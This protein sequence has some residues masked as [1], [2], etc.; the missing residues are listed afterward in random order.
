MVQK[1]YDSTEPLTCEVKMRKVERIYSPGCNFIDDSVLICILVVQKEDCVFMCFAKLDNCLGSVEYVYYE[2]TSIPQSIRRMKEFLYE[3]DVCNELIVY[4]RFEDDIDSLEEM[5]NFQMV[6]QHFCDLNAREHDFVF[7]ESFQN[8]MY[9]HLYACHNV[10]NDVKKV[11]QVDHL[12]LNVNA[13]IILLLRFAQEHDPNLIK[14]IKYPSSYSALSSEKVCC[15]NSV[16]EKIDFFTENRG[17]FSLLSCQKTRMGNRLFRHMLRNPISNGETLAFRY[18]CIQHFWDTSYEIDKLL[19]SI[20]DFDKIQRKLELSKVSPNDVH[21][22]VVSF[23]SSVVLFETLSSDV[24][25]NWIGD[26]A[27]LRSC[28]LYIE[29]IF[30]LKQCMNNVNGIMDCEFVELMQLKSRRDQLYNTIQEVIK[31]LETLFASHMNSAVQSVVQLHVTAGGEY[32]LQ[33]TLKRAKMI[34]NALNLC[35]DKPNFIQDFVVVQSQKN[36]TLHGSF[37][38]HLHQYANVI[39]E[40]NEVR[41]HK[42]LETVEHVCAK[43]SVFISD[44]SEFVSNVDVFYTFAKMA[45]SRSYVRPMIMDDVGVIRSTA[46]RHPIIEDIVRKDGKEYVTNDVE[47]GPMNSWILHGVN[48]VGKSS[49]L[50]SIVVNVVLAQCGFFVAADTFAFNPFCVIGCRIGNDDDLFCGQS[51]FVKECIEMDS[52]MTKSHANPTLVVTDEMCSSTESESARKVVASFIQVLSERRVTFACATHLF[53]LQK[54]NFIRGLRNVKNFHLDVKVDDKHVVFLRKLRP[55]L[56]SIQEYGTIV[57]KC[58][59]KDRR[60]QSLVQSSWHTEREND[61]QVSVSSYNRRSLRIK[62]E[63]CEYKPQTPLDSRL[64]THHIKFQCTADMLGN[65]SN[66]LH[67]DTLCNLVTVCQPCHTNIHNGGITIHGY[68]DSTKGTYL[69]YTIHETQ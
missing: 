55:G 33:C 49:L 64:H 3:N 63:I 10:G 51:S 7:H 35:A 26:D 56:P 44:L 57:A 36:A 8:K 12:D 25:Q 67:K 1:K 31:Y 34:S 42:F 38:Q 20:Y 23:R 15:I 66:G 21:K 43:T 28:L 18:E 61:S 48:S 6:S 27:N 46:L 29:K 52:I 17:V 50:K 54:N 59:V 22:L 39:T 5:C 68:K 53:E 45:R 58:I 30:D 47:L 11:I 16:F 24:T 60:F 9:E 40:L 2:V 32:T 37:D 4:H 69:D 14:N 65:V 13:C 62:C 19:S 41:N